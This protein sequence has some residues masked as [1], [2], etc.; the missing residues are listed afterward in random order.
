ME[1]STGRSLKSWVEASSL[2]AAVVYAFGW[3]F[4]ARLYA[5]FDVTPEEVGFSFAFLL[6]RVVFIVSAFAA[7]VALVVWALNKLAAYSGSRRIRLRYSVLGRIASL[8]VL[9]LAII[10]LL[11]WTEFD[12]TPWWLG[13]IT[14]TI[15]FILRDI[16]RSDDDDSTSRIDFSVYGVLRSISYGFAAISIAVLVALPFW[17]ADQYANQIEEGRELRAPILPGVAGL[18]IQRVQA[19]TV[20][21]EPISP[22]IG[23]S[24][25]LHLLGSSGGFIVLYDHESESVVRVPQGRVSLEDPC[26]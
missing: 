8:V 18:S 5:R 20:D 24:A 2:L 11:R 10:V 12:F 13:V 15:S 9:A 14:G 1:A 23:T 25:C 6:I 7:I 17:A 22:R 4:T 26:S 3:I 16:A 21:A 19:T